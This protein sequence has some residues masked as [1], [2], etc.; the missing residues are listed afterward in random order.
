MENFINDNESIFI[1]KEINLLVDK[2]NSVF[3][4]SQ[5][6]TPQ[7]CLA[8]FKINS[9]SKK[10]YFQTTD[11]VFYTPALLLEH[12]GFS[13]RTV[14][15]LCSV[16][17]KFCIGDNFE[18][19]KLKTFYERFSLSKLYVLSSLSE[20]L[21]LEIEETS[22]IYPSMSVSKLKEFIKSFSECKEEEKPKEQSLVESSG[23]ILDDESFFDPK[24]SYPIEFFKDCTRDQL[25]TIAWTLQYELEKYRID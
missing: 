21:L 11:E 3:R 16:Y 24:K 23:V 19:V 18:S 9:Y 12:F 2:L 20:E 25:I 8:V 5:Q 1:D 15:S 14:R 6:N 13:Q 22:L 10:R 4:S 17:K 7:L